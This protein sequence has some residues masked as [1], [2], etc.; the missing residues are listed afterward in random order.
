MNPEGEDQKSRPVWDDRMDDWA[1]LVLA[2]VIP[3][4]TIVGALMYWT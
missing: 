4:L 1:L 2:L 3:I